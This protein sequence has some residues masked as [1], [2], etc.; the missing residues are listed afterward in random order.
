M[1]VRRPLV[2]LAWLALST[3]ACSRSSAPTPDAPPPQEVTAKAADPKP[4][5]PPE[6][7]GPVFVPP[8]SPHDND[9]PAFVHPPNDHPTQIQAAHILI[10]YKGAK[11]ADAKITRSKEEAKA[12]A[13][14]VG[15]QAR[16][17][18]DFA[19]LALKFSDDPNVKTNKGNLGE[20]TRKSMVKP[21]TDAAFGLVKQEISLDP[22][23]TAFGFHI[24]KRTE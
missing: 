16:A 20:L 3:S 4:S 7:T 1:F 18:A 6:P 17:G 22:V 21:F 12:L 19:E 9:L 8:P 10:A 24:I 23:E 2:H 11:G 14:H 13:D 5:P 15:M